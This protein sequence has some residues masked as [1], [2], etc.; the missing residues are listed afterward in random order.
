ML[1]FKKTTTNSENQL[2]LDF[3]EYPPKPLQPKTLNNQFDVV[4]I[5]SFAR[6]F[7]AIKI[8]FQFLTDKTIL[9]HPDFSEIKQKKPLTMFGEDS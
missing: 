9:D 4:Y 1:F 8:L 3:K 7:Y 5:G 6:I 2:K